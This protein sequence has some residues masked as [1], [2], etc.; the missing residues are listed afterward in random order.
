MSMV[1]IG[2]DLGEGEGAIN[3]PRAGLT[4]PVTSLFLLK[5]TARYVPELIMNMVCMG[6][7][8]GEGDDGCT[9]SWFVEACDELYLLKSTAMLSGKGE[10]TP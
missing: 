2:C 9:K 7:D 6:C 10:T 5:I 4:R 3:A 1:C 8:L